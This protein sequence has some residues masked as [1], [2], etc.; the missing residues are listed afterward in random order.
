MKKKIMAVILSCAMLLSVVPLKA[1]AGGTDGSVSISA[2][3]TTVEVGEEIEVTFKVNAE[4]DPVGSVNFTVNLSSGLEYVSHN[5]LVSRSDY[6][7]SSYTSSTGVFG[8]GATDAGKTGT[9]DVLK[10]V[11]KVTDVGTHN[12]GVTLNGVFKLDGETK[13]NFGTVDNLAITAKISATGVTID[14][15]LSLDLEESKTLTYTVNPS[16]A[17]NKIVTFASNNTAVAT[18]NETTGKV[19]AVAEGT[20]TI[21]ATTEDGNFKDTCVVTVKCLHNNKTEHPAGT[22]SCTE[23]ADGKYYTCD[24]CQ[25]MFAEDGTTVIT[26]VPK[27][28]LAKHTVS[29]RALPEYLKTTGDCQNKAVYWKSCSVC[30]AKL[31]SEGTFE[32]KFGSHKMETGLTQENDQHFYKCAVSG[33]T[34][35]ES[36]ADCSGGTAT[37]KKLAVCTTCGNEY[38]KLAAH[39]FA[40]E[41][42]KDATGH[43]YACKTPNC[44]EKDEFTTHTPNIPAATEDDDQVCTEC[45]YVMKAALGHQCQLH[46]TPVAPNEAK[47]EVEGNIAYYKCNCG[48]LYK[49]A[50]ATQKTDAESVKIKALGH[51]YTEKLEDVAHFRADAQNC[52]EKTTYWYDCSRCEQNA[53]ND[54]AATDKFF[55][56]VAGAHNIITTELGYKV[57][58]GHAHKCEFCDEHDT[59]VEHT[60]GEEATE[61]TPQT[62]TECGYV[63]TKALGHTFGKEWKSDKDNHWNVCVCGEKG[64]VAAHVDENKDGK[65]DVCGYDVPLPVV[66]VNTSTNT[67]K[68]SPKTGDNNAMILWGVLAIVSGLAAWLYADK[69]RKMVR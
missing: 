37:C 7:F 1:L 15:T 17:T 28:P 64:N 4:T 24:K 55:G 2:N 20:A 31:E 56:T 42:S 54:T 45:L 5:I 68:G 60:P 53:K 62:C 38:G 43:W 16:N 12:I 18:V 59:L 36:V 22:S 40:T 50:A 52:Q 33:C 48:K 67:G 11:V 30:N 8:C 19:T 44:T 46:L 9:F 23:K 58:E 63:I 6:M 34:H 51:D 13:M 57:K 32:D 29:Q 35:K 25:K 49:D 41:F 65:C 61:F 69:K 10:L 47:C 27:L 39:D 3:K 66:T 21:T 14:E 26:E